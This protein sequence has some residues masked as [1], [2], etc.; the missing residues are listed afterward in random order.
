M[1]AGKPAFQNGLWSE[2]RKSLARMRA[3]QSM[4]AAPDALSF[5]PDFAELAGNVVRCSVGTAGIAA[6]VLHVFELER[7]GVET[8]DVDAD[9]FRGCPPR[10]GR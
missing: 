7:V 1:S 10:D 2:R 4:A 3:A 6:E 9:R 8:V 5:A